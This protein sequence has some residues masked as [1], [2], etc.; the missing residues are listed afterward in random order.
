MTS[1]GEASCEKNVANI[2]DDDPRAE[3]YC[4]DIPSLN[5]VRINVGQRSRSI[6]VDGVDY[7]EV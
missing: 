3:I 5:S 4:G 2:N 6:F 1:S 7:L